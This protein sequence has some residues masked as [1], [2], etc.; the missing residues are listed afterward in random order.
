MFGEGVTAYVVFL[1]LIPDISA[2]RFCCLLADEIQ[3][4]AKPFAGCRELL[5]L[6]LLGLAVLLFAGAHVSCGLWC[7]IV[8]G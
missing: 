6:C 8:F 1:G 4:A 2:R 3:L 5:V 7:W